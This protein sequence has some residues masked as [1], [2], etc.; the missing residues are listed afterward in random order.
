M[1]K[2]IEELNKRKKRK[3]E[4]LPKDIGH[5]KK[6]KVKKKTVIAKKMKQIR[7]NFE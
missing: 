5:S 3:K 7:H 1:N 4:R 6:R 2:E